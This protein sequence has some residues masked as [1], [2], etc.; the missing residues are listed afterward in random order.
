MTADFEDEMPRSNKNLQLY[1]RMIGTISKNDKL[2]PLTEEAVG[3]V[4][5]Q[6][7]RDVSHSLKF[8]THLSTLADL[9]KE[10]DYYA[11]KSKHEAIEKGDIEKAL[12]AKIQRKNRRFF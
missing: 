5:E 4:I 2:L 7:S 1:A 10:A 8:S 12:K 6:S 11:S 3:R 9:L